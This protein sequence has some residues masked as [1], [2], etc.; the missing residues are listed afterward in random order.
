MELI[1]SGA[2]LVD[3]FL[4]DRIDM[5]KWQFWLNDPSMRV[6]ARQGSLC[7]CG[8]TSVAE[9]AF[10]ALTTRRLYPADAMLMAEVTM[11]CNCEQVGTY[12]FVTHLCN[13]LCGDEIQTLS[14]PDNNSEVTFGRMREKL[15]WFFW[16]FNDGTEFHK[17]VEGEEP[18]RPFGDEGSAFRTVRASYDIVTRELEGAVLEGGRWMG[19]GRQVRF[20][21]FFSAIELKIVAQAK[22]LEL[23][24]HFRNCRLFPHPA[25]NPVRVF[26]GGPSRKGNTEA[27]IVNRNGKSLVRSRANADG[28]IFLGLPLDACFPLSG[29]LEVIE[30]PEVVDS[31]EILSDGIHGIY[32]GD[33]YASSIQ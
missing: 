3:G 17:W 10:T 2:Y 29:R 27:R 9:R 12:G 4:G 18:L 1:K 16:W 19:I 14:I 15:G 24:V 28:L 26:V 5:S 13:R 30:G 23:E 7:I 8:T 11:P 33:F 22:G 6:H 31:M 32:P 25:H 20:L 21:K